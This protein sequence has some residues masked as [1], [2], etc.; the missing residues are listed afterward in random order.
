MLLQ[1]QALLRWPAYYLLSVT[2]WIW[3]TFKKPQTLTRNQYHSKKSVQI[4]V[5]QN[6]YLHG[7]QAVALMT[8]FCGR[9]S[10]PFPR[11]G[12]NTVMLLTTVASQCKSFPEQTVLLCCWS[13]LLLYSCQKKYLCSSTLRWRAIWT[14]W[15]TQFA[16]GTRDYNMKPFCFLI[17][18]QLLTSC[19]WVKQ[20]LNTHTQHLHLV[21]KSN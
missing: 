6:E 2:R 21:P 4:N 13:I 20:S 14:C 3:L 7:T 11:Q 18:L 19:T 12:C 8:E 15:S 16:L 9:K 1:P 17:N 10:L 5:L